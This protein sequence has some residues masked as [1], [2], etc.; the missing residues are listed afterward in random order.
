[1]GNALGLRVG[2]EDGEGDDQLR[3]QLGLLRPELEEHQRVAGPVLA[4]RGPPP[5]VYGRARCAS[6]RSIN[7]SIVSSCA[8]REHRQNV[9]LNVSHAFF[10]S[11]RVVFI[12]RACFTRNGEAFTITLA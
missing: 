3:R 8:R 7:S 6:K 10:L 5:A 9:Q 2:D 12:G 1:M 11:V 4:A